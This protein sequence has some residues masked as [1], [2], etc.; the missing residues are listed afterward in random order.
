[1]EA[2]NYKRQLIAEEKNKKLEFEKKKIQHDYEQEITK[3]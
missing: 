1:M 2:V 3:C